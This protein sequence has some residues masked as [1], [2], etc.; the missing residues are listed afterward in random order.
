MSCRWPTCLSIH[1]SQG[2][3]FPCV[4]IP[5]HTQHYM[6]LQRNLLY[7]AVTRGKR[8]VILVGTKKALA[9]AVKRQDTRRRVHGVEEEV[10][11]NVILHGTACRENL[12]SGMRKKPGVADRRSIRHR[13]PTVVGTGKGK[14]I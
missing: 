3:E 9:M 14:V 4:V 13:E 12:S 11:G 10:G 2:S 6:M 7:T 8:L 1:K 5:I